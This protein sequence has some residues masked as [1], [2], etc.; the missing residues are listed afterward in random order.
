MASITQRGGRFF[1]R[2]RRHGYPA[3]AKTFTRKSDASAW[4][5]RIEADME[6]GRY[7]FDEE[8]TPT[9]REAVQAYRC[10]P[11][12]TKMK[13]AADYA[14]R[15]DQ[16]EALCFAGKPVDTV[17]PADLAAW[18]DVELQGNKPA[19]VVRKL[20]MLSAIFTWAMKEQGW[21][22]SN[23]ATM[24]SR[25]RFSDRRERLLSVDEQ[26]YLL[27]A[28]ATSKATWLPAA[29]AVLMNSAMRRGELC[30]LKRR[31]VNFPAAVAHLHDTKNGRPRDVPLCPASLAALRTLTDA[32]PDRPDAPLIPVGEP[33]SVST[34]FAV[35][36]RRARAAYE[37]DCQAA[38]RKPDSGFLLDVRLH[39]QRHAAITRWASTGELSV[40]QLQAISGHQT[41][42]LLS[43]YTHLSAG[44]LAVRMGEIAKTR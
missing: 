34:R 2:V 8:A 7:V 31:D 35:T 5:R 28:A 25:P 29:L 32:A 36:V 10:T 3:I 26:R 41:P 37:A 20:A 18:R 9:L 33:G 6:A 15:Y 24:V 30:S 39:D 17:T 44:Q 42:A 14:Y 11:T 21:T 27:A 19:T 12:A 13:G 22:K 23:P 40:M 4:G 38:G 1:V 16:F 43:R